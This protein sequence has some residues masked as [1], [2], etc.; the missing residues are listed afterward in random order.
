MISARDAWSILTG[1][2]KLYQKRFSPEGAETTQRIVDSLISEYSAMADSMYQRNMF[3]ALSIG[4]LTGLNTTEMD[5][6]WNLRDPFTLDPADFKTVFMKT[7]G[8][9]E[10]YK[11]LLLQILDLINKYITPDLFKK[12]QSAIVGLLWDIY[13]V[14][15]LIVKYLNE[16]LKKLYEA[17]NFALKIVF[18]IIDLLKDIVELILKLLNIN[19]RDD[20][21]P[22]EPE[23]NVGENITETQLHKAKYGSARIGRSY[24][25]PYDLVKLLANDI[26]LLD[27]RY[28][29]DTFTSLIE[30]YTDEVNPALIYALYDRMSLND[31][32]ANSILVWDYGHW[33]RDYWHGNLVPQTAGRIGY[34]L[35]DASTYD[36][37]AIPA[38]NDQPA[39]Y[40]VSPVAPYQPEYVEAPY[41]LIPFKSATA[42]GWAFAQADDLHDVINTLKWDI[43]YWDGGFWGLENQDQYKLWADEP[44]YRVPWVQLYS[45]TYGN[46][47]R[48]MQFSYQMSALTTSEPT[49]PKVPYSN[50]SIKLWAYSET[51][52]FF[53]MR[54]AEEWLNNHGITNPALVNKYVT[55][56]W[57]Y[58][59][60]MTKSSRM[61]TWFWALA[62][63]EDQETKFIKRWEAMGLD[64]EILK[65]LLDYMKNFIAVN[66]SYKARERL[67]VM[68]YKRT[69]R[70]SSWYL[71][72]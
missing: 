71:T 16:V 50:Y 51:Q 46:Y 3:S 72:F 42:N 11:Q 20:S 59:G 30:P 62:G 36:A 22:K 44:F 21:N 40:Y 18:N 64:P 70:R 5:W 47:G 31:V 7:H 33:D 2:K 24:Y 27:V 52:L 1:E 56:L 61:K 60:L 69:I 65:G 53:I 54:K 35:V 67:K 6:L 32:V 39:P 17:L 57:N 19:V 43:G 34:A 14:L 45:D 23:S 12:L 15:K 55:A 63:I 41:G 37:D 49:A 48:L 29:P 25:D 13:N 28:E 58:Y 68:S 4:M 10:W 38:F 26:M 8:L 9:P 66:A